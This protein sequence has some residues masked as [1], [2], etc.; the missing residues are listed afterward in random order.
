VKISIVTVCYNSELTIAQT[1]ASVA[2]QCWTDY[3]HIVIDGAS[4]DNTMDIV[5]AHK[6]DKLIAASAPDKGIYDAMNKGLALATGDYVAFL[7]SDDLYARSDAIRLVAERALETSADCIM[8]DVQFFDDDPT[9]PSGRH[10]SARNF[11]K[12]W[13][14][15]GIMPP[16][17]GLFV[18]RSLLNDAGGFDTSYR[19]AA[20]FDLVARI[21]LKHGA[22]WSV[23]GKTITLFRSG[24]LSTQGG[25]IRTA[26][27]AE[28]ARSL[29][30]LN[31]ALPGARIWLRYPVKA[32]QYIPFKAQR[33]AS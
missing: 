8:G 18:K 24:G 13:M 9:R 4:S 3:E 22:S 23:L 6:H 2:G 28:F 27:S 12:W 14:K 15:I 17:P 29:R 11:S 7:N 26:L 21:I 31:V 32:L 10:Y 19:I 30:A 16:H 33:K 1:L 25:L 20:D 5:V